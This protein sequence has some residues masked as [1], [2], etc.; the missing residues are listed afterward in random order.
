[1]ARITD[2][3]RSQALASG[4]Y[5]TAARWAALHALANP[6]SHD[7]TDQQADPRAVAHA[8]LHLMQPLLDAPAVTRNTR[9]LRLADLDPI[10]R[11][12][13][14]PAN[15]VEHA[16]RDLPTRAP[17]ANRVAAAIIGVP[18]PTVGGTPLDR[19]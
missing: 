14:L 19:P 13:P 10:L 6:D 15:T 2:R 9:L 11:T 4:D 3:W 5:D 18:G 17:L 8:W 16:M 7:P 1:M 12:N